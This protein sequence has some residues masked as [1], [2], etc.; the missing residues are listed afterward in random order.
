MY[1]KYTKK[2]FFSFVKGFD[3]FLRERRKTM[4][5]WTL[6]DFQEYFGFSH[7]EIDKNGEET[8]KDKYVR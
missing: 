8:G 5:S 1:K 7:R 2:D 3:K 4:K 6:E